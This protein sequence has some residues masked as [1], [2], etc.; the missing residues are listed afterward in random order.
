MNALDCRDNPIGLSVIAAIS[1]QKIMGQPAD[2]TTGVY[3]ILR[4]VNNKK[5]GGR[6]SFRPDVK[7][8]VNLLAG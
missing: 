3:L 8:A 7:Q 1:R 4:P 6:I 2:K 5:P